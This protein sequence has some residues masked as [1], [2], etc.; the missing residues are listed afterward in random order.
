MIKSMKK[1]DFIFNVL[2]I[3]KK[4]NFV[5]RTKLLN[6]L[7][8]SAYFFFRFVTKTENGQIRRTERKIPFDCSK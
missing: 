5:F 1:V 7:I 4:N 3:M 8:H 2:K 6:K